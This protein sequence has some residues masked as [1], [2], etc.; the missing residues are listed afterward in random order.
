MEMFGLDIMDKTVLQKIVLVLVCTF[1]FWKIIRYM[2]DLLKV[3]KEPVTVLV[4]GAAGMIHLFVFLIEILVNLRKCYVLYYQSHI[5]VPYYIAH[6]VVFININLKIH[7]VNC[8][9]RSGLTATIHWDSTYVFR[10]VLPIKI[11]IVNS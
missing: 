11:N 5:F 3:E 1:L 2:S 10:F 4:T 7:R 8:K 9:W 6:K